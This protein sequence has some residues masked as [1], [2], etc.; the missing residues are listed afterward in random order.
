M[1]CLLL[2]LSLL[3]AR[4]PSRACPRVPSA[5]LCQ[6]SDQTAPLQGPG[7]HWVPLSTHEI[8]HFPSFPTISH[9]LF[10]SSWEQLEK[11]RS[12]SPPNT[13]DSFQLLCLCEKSWSILKCEP[14]GWVGLAFQK[15]TLAHR[16][17]LREQKIWSDLGSSA[18]LVNQRSAAAILL[19]AGLHPKSLC[20]ALHAL[21]PLSPVLTLSE[22]LSW[23]WPG[24][25]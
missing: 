14:S 24:Q 1:R 6:C 20:V 2:L 18:P 19:T 22:H 10:S 15:K 11:D 4:L 21:L 8:F 17:V 5:L 16:V 12:V 25:G 23:V 13:K 3:C 7:G 9:T